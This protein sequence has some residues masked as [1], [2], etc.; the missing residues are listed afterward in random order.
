MVLPSK[1]ADEEEDDDEGDEP[2][3]PIIDESPGNMED[4][5]DPL[6][7][8]TGAFFTGCWSSSPMEMKGSSDFHP[9][10]RSLMGSGSSGGGGAR[11]ALTICLVTR[12]SNPIRG[13]NMGGN[14]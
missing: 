2:P 14:R 10:L 1:G 4:K 6:D 5:T 3:L 12:A 7:E 9:D 11:I 8:E 13:E